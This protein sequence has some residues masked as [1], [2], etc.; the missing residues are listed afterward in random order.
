MLICSQKILEGVLLNTEE[1]TTF[2][3]KGTYRETFKTTSQ[4]YPLPHP[5]SDISPFF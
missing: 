3:V 4:T 5:P 2:V 1:T